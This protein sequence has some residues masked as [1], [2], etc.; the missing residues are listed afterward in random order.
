MISHLLSLKAFEVLRQA[1][2][3]PYFQSAAYSARQKLECIT[4]NWVDLCEEIGHRHPGICHARSRAMSVP[5]QR[6]CECQGSNCGICSSLHWIWGPRCSQWPHPSL[7]H[8]AHPS[9]MLDE[10]GPLRQAELLS[11]RYVNSNFSLL[12]LSVTQGWGVCSISHPR[13]LPPP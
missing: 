13:S 12:W 11:F 4:A 10:E 9:T 2:S 5:V 8:G 3:N 7:A 6:A 1:V